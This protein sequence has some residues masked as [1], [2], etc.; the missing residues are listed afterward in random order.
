MAASWM[1]DGGFWVVGWMSGFS[2]EET[3][4][5]WTAVAVAV[6]IFGLI[7]VLALAAVFRLV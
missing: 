5:T 7:Q 6:G 1:N 2:E 4:R 3:L